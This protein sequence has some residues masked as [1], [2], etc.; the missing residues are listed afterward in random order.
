[1]VGPSRSTQRREVPARFRAAE[2]LRAR[3]RELAQQRPRYGY[4][5]LCAMLRAEG[6]LVNHKRSTALP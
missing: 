3:L 1:M 5:R 6:L 2:T 4:R